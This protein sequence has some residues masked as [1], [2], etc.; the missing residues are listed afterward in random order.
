MMKI[1][2]PRR[3]AL[4]LIA[5]F[6]GLSAYAQTSTI[7]G[8]VRDTAG[9]P[10]VGAAVMVKGTTNG[11]MTNADGSYSIKAKDDA[12]LVCQLFGYKT[13]EQTVGGRS[14]ID[15]T[16]ADDTEMLEATV[17]VGYG[18]LKKTQLVGSV[19]N[20][21]GDKVADRPNPNLA[22]SLQGQVAGLNII[23]TDGKA[24]HSGNVYIRTNA[25]KYTTRAS[26]TSG[27]GGAYSIGSGDGSALVLID[28]V[29]GSLGNV[30]PSDIETVAVLKDASS[31]AI[32]GARAYNGVILV[33]TKEAKGDKFTISYNGTYSYNDRTIKWE[34]NI[35]TDGLTW[36][37]AFYDFFQGDS[38]TPTSAGKMPS[39]I[40]T[41]K[42]NDGYLDTFRQ[43]RIAGNYDVFDDTSGVYQY[44]GSTNWLPLFYKRGTDNTTHDIS[45]R[46]SSKKITYS[47]TGRYFTQSGLYKI[48]DDSYNQFNIRSKVKLQ[49]TDWLSINNNTS[50]F[51]TNQRQSMFTTGSVLG[52]Q[53]DQHGQ[54]IG[55]PVNPN[56]TYS[57]FA[58]KT[59]FASFLE[60]NTGQT[61]GNTTVVTTTGATI[62]FLKDVLKF[63][64][65]F[66]YKAIRR[67]R[68]RYRAPLTFYLSDTSYT[69]YVPQASSY[70]SRWTYDTDY[71]TANAYFTFTPKLG[72]NHELNVVAGTNVENYNY[73]RFYLQ[74]KGMIFPDK[75]ESYEMYDALETILIE[76]NRNSYG[77][78]GF[79]GRANYTL[80]KRYILEIAA[81]YDG[82]SRFPSSSR[83][84]FFPSM[85]VGWRVSE[86]PWMQWS[87]SWLDNFKIR[88][89][90]GTLGNGTSGV[91]DFLELINIDKT[92]VLFD[93]AK[94]NYTGSPNVVPESLTWERATTYDVGIDADFLGNRLSFSGDWF[95]R[96]TKDVITAGPTLPATFGA[97]APKGNFSRFEDRGWELT[98]A[99][100]DQFKLG[101]KDFRYSIQGRM[102]DT[103]TTVKEFSTIVE[104]PLDLYAGKEL[105][106]IWGFR[107]DGIFRNNTEAQSWATDTF[108]K[109][110]SNFVEYAG[111]LRFIDI[112]GDGDINYGL[113][114]MQDHGDLEVIGNE[115]P[116]Y[117]YGANLD[118]N[119]NG[120]GLSLFFQGVGKRDWYPDT[121][122]A[123]FWGSYNRPYCPYLNV[124]Q[125]GDNYPQI[126]FSTP[127]WEVVN[128][129]KNPYWTRRVAYA[130]NRNVGPL[131]WNN[132]HYL[133]NAAYLRLKNVTIDYTLPQNLTR[134]VNI[135]KARFYVTMEN[136]FT[137]SP[138]FKHTNMF[139][140]EAIGLGDTDFDSGSVSAGN[141]GLSGVGEGYSYPMFKT[142]TFGVSITL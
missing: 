119:W 116:R 72:E 12:V 38:V 9:D 88:A 50:L 89:N 14:N 30:N 5:L 40:N 53:I 7:T 122:T 112:D 21:D 48:G 66:S 85:S 64:A 19:E 125:I 113:G 97:G 96:D 70:K 29:E 81:R 121:E 56:G 103:K 105:G 94:N 77:N 107:T 58:A 35:V 17:V 43:R 101:G 67:W 62:T 102:W 31:A 136:L 79:F 126:D 82:A 3:F 41:W 34:D 69:E 110:G 68:E 78:L 16:L 59:G 137:W 65:D 55:I 91:Y 46:G 106:E 28:G 63:D 92:D 93:G 87:R 8:V 18:T 24:N 23:Q 84:G 131:S 71:I 1:T 11:V 139:D 54:P 20:L 129:D 25:H 61:D 45:V 33:T 44:Y 141:A 75:Y 135:E 134:K 51:R 26:M 140:P 6:A 73:D 123:F 138:L 120:I 15:F 128:Y 22:R 76:Q 37:E 108:H 42:F 80:L 13:Q 27:S 86:E 83:W 133:Q 2:I 127:N 118:F 98:L 95:L 104:N 117:M 49:V 90:W 32:Y 142:F 36:L 109:N 114:T 52:K 57:L 100:K 99:W 60:G 74:R 10:I 130:S 4:A 39:Q 47:L 132:D 111:D 124:N 115:T